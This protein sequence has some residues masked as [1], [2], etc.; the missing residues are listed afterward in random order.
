MGF[1][2]DNKVVQA[3]VLDRLDPAFGKCIEDR[4][5]RPQ[6]SNRSNASPQR[7]IE[8]PS[9]VRVTVAEHQ[10]RLFAGRLDVLAEGL[11]L[12][13]DPRRVGMAS[14]WGDE[15]APTGDRQGN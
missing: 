1:A 9:K 2:H 15:Y 6:T 14:G 8:A 7:V 3:L 13:A 10:R 12:L 11:G 5:H 4:R